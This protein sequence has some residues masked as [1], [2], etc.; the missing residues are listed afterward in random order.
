M[1]RH[2]YCALGFKDLMVERKKL[3]LDLE[4]L[5]LRLLLLLP[6]DSSEM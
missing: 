5:V 2:G 3:L 1:L 4:T 6:D